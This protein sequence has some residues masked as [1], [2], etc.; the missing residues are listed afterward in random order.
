[1]I[2]SDTFRHPVP[3]PRAT[4]LGDNNVD[5]KLVI[6]NRLVIKLTT[7]AINNDQI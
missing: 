6:F 7:T 1:M 2:M 4:L 3:E 5:R